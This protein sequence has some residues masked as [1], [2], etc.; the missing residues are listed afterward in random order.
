MNK[1]LFKTVAAITSVLALGSAVVACNDGNTPA[2]PSDPVKYAVS[3]SLNGGVGTLPTETNKRE[4]EKFTLASATGLTKENYTFD[5]WHDGTTKYAAG[6]EYTMPAHAVTFTAQWKENEGNVEFKVTYSLNGGVGT[7]PTET[8]KREGEKFTLASATGL[9]KENYTFY[10]WHDGAVKYDAGAQ[11]TMPARDVTLTAV[12]EENAPTEYSVTYR[13]GVGAE[14]TVPAGGIYE[15]GNDVILP[16]P[17]GL[18]KDG[19][20]FNG[21]KDDES[22]TVYNVGDKFS[23]PAKNVTLTAQW[24]VDTSDV[25]PS[26]KYSVTVVKSSIDRQLPFITG[27]IPIIDNKACGETFKIPSDTF[28]YAHYTLTSWRVQKYVGE[29]AD[30]YWE[31]LNNYKPDEDI[32][33]PETNIRVVA[34]W[35]ANDVTISFN[36]NGGSGTMNSIKKKYDS[37]MAFTTSA[38]DCKF[39]APAGK[40]FQGWATSANGAVLD[41]GTK[42]DS[43][44]VSAND[45]LTLYAIWENSDQPTVSISDLIGSWTNGTDVLNIGSDNLGNAYAQGSGILN[46]K[47]LLYVLVGETN[48]VF[49]LDG[50]IY[51]DITY[52]GSTLTLVSEE[53][54]ITFT[55][56]TALSDVPVSEFVG[57]WDKAL[58]SGSQPWVI[59]ADK[60]YYNK[61]LNAANINVIGGYI[62]IYYESVGY[63]Y[64]YLLKKTGDNLT[65]FYCAPEKAP[66]AVTFS[67]GTFILLTVSGKPNQ[68][69]NSGAAPDATKIKQ[70][71]APEGKVF[72][73][74]VIKG[75]QTEFNVADV[76]TGDVSIEAVF[77]DAAD[78][79]IKTYVGTPSANNGRTSKI[80]VDS[81]TN[82]ITFYFMLNGSETEKTFIAEKRDEGYFISASDNPTGSKLWVVISSDGNT[83]SLYDDW[84]GP[85]EKQGGDFM[86]Q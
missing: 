72:S 74:W 42:L 47:Y 4:G 57:K 6:A 39:T 52:T 51:Y 49:S 50:S 84:N 14:G 63:N 58:T 16:N 73:K 27:D 31:T 85:D 23:M 36:A 2:G 21:W 8:N 75:T 7:L 41:N 66:E 22:G 45:T 26:V 30:G 68:I 13:A 55:S 53:G 11:Y 65:G 67:S 10:G 3:Y 20:V 38:F 37:N 24:K 71:V 43:A 69:V 77:V 64:V 61:S 78:S 40:A 29:G 17:T 76:M 59:A 19:Y 46:G 34:V 82:E 15:V 80:V 5:G 81:A 83:L 62:S 86:A 44:I 70:P 1:K 9:T 12:W 54:N 48:A 60:A 35:T 25:D 56:K 28:T 18:N 32:E 33:M 79:T